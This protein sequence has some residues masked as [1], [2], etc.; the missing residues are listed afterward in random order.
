[1]SDARI[2][3][4]VIP[5]AA[6]V[7]AGIIYVAGYLVIRYAAIPSDP[8]SVNWPEAGKLALSLC[9]PLIVAAYI[10]LIGYVN[11]DAKRR[12]MRSVMWT[13]LAIFIPNAIGI[14]LYFLLR[15]PMPMICSGCGATVK[16]TFT[17]CPHCSTPMRPTCTQCGRGIERGW[18]HCPYCG[19]AAPTANQ[20]PPQS[21]QPASGPVQT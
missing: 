7:I 13:L 3:T 20:L 9:A 15:D 10:L 2:E 21:T 1:M 14:I 18:R 16:S 12:G 8:Q 6:Y 17:F 11:G 5:K 19:A 4:S